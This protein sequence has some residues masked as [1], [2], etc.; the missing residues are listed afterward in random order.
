MVKIMKIIKCLNC[1]CSFTQNKKTQ[2]FCSKHCVNNFVRCDI[3][4][5]TCE[6]C[7]NKFNLRKST[8][9]N[10]FGVTR[11]CNEKCR[12]EI[13]RLDK[14]VNY[15]GGEYVSE[16]GDV[17]ILVS[18]KNCLSGAKII[19]RALKR[20]VVEK[21]INRKLLT[22]ECVIH[23]NGNQCMPLHL[24]IRMNLQTNIKNTIKHILIIFNM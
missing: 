21:I 5:Y 19:Y 14:S 8:V 2:K 15:K 16:V 20:I 6:C 12:K 10:R 22:S 9:K 4:T 13:M 7:K 24:D 17:M 23:I 3:I 1:S 18:G 11:F